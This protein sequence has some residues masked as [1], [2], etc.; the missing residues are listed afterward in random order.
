MEAYAYSLFCDDIRYELRNK[1]SLIG[2]YTGEL[3]VPSFPF[4]LLRLCVA[5]TAVF[6]YGAIPEQVIVRI[7]KDDE[8]MSEAQTSPPNAEGVDKVLETDLAA[9]NGDVQKVVT[10]K[11]YFE[12]P[13]ISMQ[14]PGLIRV[15]V[16]AGDVELKAGA[17]RI[18]AATP[19]E[20]SAMGMVIPPSASEIVGDD[21]IHPEK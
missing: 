16:V 9:S 12:F 5:V 10:L 19:E 7:L 21:S 20:A 8:V 13:M 1:V 3:I 17:L 15:R 11:Q 14:S 18:R 4:F 2:I 6:P